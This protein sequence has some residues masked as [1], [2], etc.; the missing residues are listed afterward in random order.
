MVLLDTLANNAVNAFDGGHALVSHDMRLISQVAKEIWICE[1]KIVELYKGND[2]NFMT[3]LH[4]QIGIDKGGNGSG[5]G[6]LILQHWLYLG[7]VAVRVF[8]TYVVTYVL[9]LAQ[10]TVF[11]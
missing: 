3:A 7:F 4:A 1:N 5:A 9:L 2:Q 11:N 8:N 10:K 6:L